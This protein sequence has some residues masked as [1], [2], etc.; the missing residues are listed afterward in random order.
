MKQIAFIDCAV[1][2][3]ETLRAG[4]RPGIE[5]VM[6]SSR[7][8]APRQIAIAL[9]G[10]CDVEAIHIV[11]HGQPGE[12]SFGAGALS[13]ET[14]EEHRSH[15]AE[16]G[17]ALAADG[18]IRLWV[19]DAARGQR[20]AAFLNGLRLA[21]GA[22]V[23]GATGLVGAAA[24]GARWELDASV[25]GTA[26]PPL[27]AEGIANYAGVMTN[28]TDLALSISDP[29]INNAEKGAVAFTTSGIDGDVTSATVTFSD[30][31]H[32]VTV[33]A[34][35][36]VADLSGFN[37][38]PVSSVLIVT[39]GAA[40][41]VL[42]LGS[43]GEA[44]IALQKGLLA[45]GGAG[46]ATDPGPADGSFGPHTEAAI[47]AYQSQH[48]LP[49]D[50]VVGPTTWWAPAGAGGGTLASLADLA[51]GN[52]ASANGAAIA[53]DT[54]ADSGGDLAL[55]ISDPSI[56]NAEKGAVAFTTSG[57]DGDVTSATVTFSDGVHSVTVDASAGV[58]DLT[59]FNDGPVSSQLN[60]TDGAGNT[61]SANGATIALDTTADG[62]GDLALSISDPSINN[63]E[64]GAVAFTTSGIDGDVTSATVTFSDGVHSVTVNASAGV[65]DLTGFNDGPVSS[66]LNVT[67]GAAPPVLQLGS[68]GEAVIALQKALLEFGGAGSA[69]DPGPADGSFGRA[70]KPRSKPTSP[71]MDCP[72]TAWSVQPHGGRLRALAGGRWHRLPT[73][74]RA[75]RRRPTGPR[76]PSTPRRMAAATWRCRSATARSTMP[77]RVRWRSRRRASTAT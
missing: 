15:L 45:F 39:D 60:V 23:L 42:Q 32:S 77:R 61:A 17:R 46:S 22:A 3:I 70:P 52:T 43:T 25:G 56:N 68:T 38:G 26:Q 55:S 20:G 67:D 4:L 48:G 59:G 64:K 40:P 75:T 57:I 19:C 47:K 28:A 14:I 66:Q 73:W 16:I 36:G 71:S 6:L 5:A 30:G 13:L 11:A 65:A 44:V 74:R 33:D 21:T 9:Q 72:V 27:T 35:A 58:A 54:T 49:G 12:V 18:E 8:A 41:P 76:S 34:S 62:G 37:D 10:R 2:D 29:S 50:G 31:V 63:A 24:R 7:Q 53:L 1:A 69:T 51:T